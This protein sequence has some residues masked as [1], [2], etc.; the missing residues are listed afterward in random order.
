MKVRNV[1]NKRIFECFITEKPKAFVRKDQ[2]EI[3]SM[4]SKKS[5]CAQRNSGP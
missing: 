5:R 2:D 1:T 3:F 4:L